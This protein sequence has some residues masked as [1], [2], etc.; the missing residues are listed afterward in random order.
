MQGPSLLAISIV[1]KPSVRGPTWT[2]VG[3]SHRRGDKF[4]GNGESGRQRRG[5]VLTRLRGRLP[6][7]GSRERD[8]L[9]QGERSRGWIRSKEERERQNRRKGRPIY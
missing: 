3:I 4:E 5:R 9:G 1:G 8:D 6:C 2:G 7:P